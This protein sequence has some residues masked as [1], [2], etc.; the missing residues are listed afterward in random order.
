ML[1]AEEETSVPRPRIPE[2]TVMDI[3]KTQTA[4]L[5]KDFDNSSIFIS[6]TEPAMLNAMYMLIRGRTIS[7]ESLDTTVTAPSISVLYPA[8][9]EIYPQA[10]VIDE[11][12]GINPSMKSEHSLITFDAEIK[13]SF[14]GINTAEDT[15]RTDTAFIT[16]PVCLK[17]SQKLCTNEHNNAAAKTVKTALNGSVILSFAAFNK[18]FIKSIKDRERISSEE[19]FF[20]PSS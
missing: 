2:K 4:K 6:D 1:S 18:R 14:I 15:A 19:K 11:Y 12:R 16:G 8:A 7:E 13:T 20:M 17:L 3:P 5:L 10:A 9:E